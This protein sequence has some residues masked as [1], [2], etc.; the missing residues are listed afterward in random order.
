MAEN[1]SEA[2]YNHKAILIAP[3]KDIIAFPAYGGY[4]IYGYSDEGGF[5]KRA[6]IK[7]SDDSRYGSIRGLY[8]GDYVYIISGNSLS[9]LDL[10][11]LRGVLKL[12]F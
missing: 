4:V 12:D 2:L 7:G 9:V 1:R 11:T 6:Q 8:I 10:Q 5:Y 3:D